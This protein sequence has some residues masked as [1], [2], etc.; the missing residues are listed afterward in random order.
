MRFRGTRGRGTD[1]SASREDREDREAVCR[2]AA[3]EVAATRLHGDTSGI[4]RT[5]L[6]VAHCALHAHCTVA[7]GCAVA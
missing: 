3:R 2:M 4:V 6:H 5:A 7:L 1:R